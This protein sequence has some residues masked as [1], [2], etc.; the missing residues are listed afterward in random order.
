MQRQR[1]KRTGILTAVNKNSLVR[2]PYFLYGSVY[3]DGKPWKTRSA[4][5]KP[6]DHLKQL[7][8]KAAFAWEALFPNEPYTKLLRNS[9]QSLINKNQG[10]L[11][12]SSKIKRQV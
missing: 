2:P 5:G 3:A 11:P 7:R 12:D 1:Y 6:A 8:T 9:A 10:F 4:H